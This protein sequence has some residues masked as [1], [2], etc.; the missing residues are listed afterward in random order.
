VS[1]AALSA[2]LTGHPWLAQ[3]HAGSSGALLLLSAS[4]HAELRRHGRQSLLDHLQTHLVAHATE[5]AQHLR[6]LDTAPDEL[7]V[8]T[9]DRWLLAPRPDRVTPLIEQAQDDR[10]TLTLQLPLELI[11]FDGHFPQAPVLPGVLQVGWAL[12]LAAPRLGTSMH[13]RE[14]EALKFQ[15][16]LHPGDCIE[17]TLHFETDPQDA[18]RGKLH[19]AYRLDGE[20]CSS[21]RLK[22]ERAHD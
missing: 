12:A 15:R 3:V 11:H 9:I 14:M 5:P 22:V 19:F 8:S 10:W 7:D 18:T 16:L 13:C 1:T 6:L 17:L 21:G 20:H 4:G 2:C